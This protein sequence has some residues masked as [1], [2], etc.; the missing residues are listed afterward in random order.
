MDIVTTRDNFQTLVDIVIANPTCTNLVQHV[1]M[2]TTHP[3][4]VDAQ[5]NA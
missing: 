4:V 2:K 1:S 5:D 3:I